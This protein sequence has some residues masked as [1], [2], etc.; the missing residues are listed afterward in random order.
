MLNYSF[1]KREK[2]LLAILAVVA[3]IIAWYQLVFVN[4]QNQMAE[5]DAKIA[6]VQDQAVQNQ[7]KAAQYK[8]M[9]E[10]VEAYKAQ[11]IAPIIVPNYDNTQSLMAYLNGVIPSDREYTIDFDDPVIAEDGTVHRVGQITYE[12]GSY[13][14]ARAVA[15]NIA[16]GPYPCTVDSLS[17]VKKS[18]GG[19]SSDQ[20]FTTTG[21][22]TFIEKNTGNAKSGDKSS[23]ENKGQDLSKMSDWNK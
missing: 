2:F 19:S 1:S 5:L 20:N 9:S 11:G 3:V 14:E 4:V 21:K 17:I 6:E 7:T 18:K 22:L 10:E 8:K 13:E 23:Q 15:Q 12:T 16:L